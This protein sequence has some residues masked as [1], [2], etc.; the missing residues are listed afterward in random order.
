MPQYGPAPGA[1]PGTGATL[2]VMAPQDMSAWEWSEG[3]PPPLAAGKQALRLWAKAVRARARADRDRALDEAVCAAI[4]ASPLFQRADTVGT[5][6]PMVDEVDVEPLM[7]SLADSGRR[8][9]APRVQFQPT[10]HLTFHELTAGTELHPWGVREPAPHAPKV[11]PEEIDLLLVPGLLFDEYGGRL[12]YGKGF[13]DRFLARHGDRFATVGVTF[14]AL[15]VPRLPQA[16][17][18]VAVRYLVTETGLEPA[19]LSSSQV[20]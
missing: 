17:H 15:V 13:Y 1:S 16:K 14:D 9:V 18:D 7:E 6:L 12:G 4:V 20:G 2:R 19:V 8:F 10:P 11:A 5:Y 3:A